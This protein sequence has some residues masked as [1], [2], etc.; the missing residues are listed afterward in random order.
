MGSVVAFPN[1]L[2]EQ[3]SYCVFHAVESAA[4][5]SGLYVEEYIDNIYYDDCNPSEFSNKKNL[6]TIYLRFHRLIEEAIQTIPGNKP[7]DKADRAYLCFRIYLH[8]MTQERDSLDEAEAS[9]FLAHA[10]REYYAS[11]GRRLTCMEESR[12]L[13]DITLASES[14][15]EKKQ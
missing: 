1:R 5:H 14:S 7:I 6:Q 15:P 8:A 13:H 2:H 3:F 9:Y 4:Q 12:I 11:K 10:L